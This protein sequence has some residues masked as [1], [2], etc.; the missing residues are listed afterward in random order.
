M[1]G[2]KERRWEKLT[3]AW[4]L[5]FPFKRT[6]DSK[7]EIGVRKDN[8]SSRVFRGLTGFR[9]KNQKSEKEKGLWLKKKKKIIGFLVG[10]LKE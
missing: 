7:S 10:A 8:K 4:G 5:F 1:L 2:E 9:G 6:A 3:Q